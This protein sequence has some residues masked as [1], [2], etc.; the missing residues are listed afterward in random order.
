MTIFEQLKDIIHTKSNQLAVDVEEEKEF[1]PFLVQRWLSMHSDE[2]A[3]I[4]NES[5][6]RFW[7]VMDDKI[8]WYKMFQGM[9][10]R[11]HPKRITYIKKVG[12]KETPEKEL[13]DR[14][15]QTLEISKRECKLYLEQELINKKQIKKEIG[16]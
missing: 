14:L 6:N 5:T 11:R 2:F 8:M 9:M 7:R 1:Q 4:C 10:P 13:I 3:N 15:S 16:L 12:K